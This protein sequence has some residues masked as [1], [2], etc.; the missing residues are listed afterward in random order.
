MSVLKTEDPRIYSAFQT[1][2][3]RRTVTQTNSVAHCLEKR[4]DS[5]GRWFPLN[6][7]LIRLGKTQ[8][9]ASG[10]STPDR[11][12]LWTGPGSY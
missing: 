4:F 3:Q 2:E 11:L 8:A 12:R 9:G 1:P 6:F 5:G 7:L 10:S